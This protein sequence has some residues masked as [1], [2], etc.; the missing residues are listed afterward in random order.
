MISMNL[1]H[2][3][4]KDA[5]G[6][7]LYKTQDP[8]YYNEILKNKT[9]LLWG[10]SYFPKIDKGIRIT[11]DCAIEV[12]NPQT[13]EISHSAM[14]RVPMYNKDDL[15]INYENVYYPGNI[16]INQL[17]ST[18][19]VLNGLSQQIASALPNNQYYN[20]VRY[21][22]G[23]MQPNIITIDPVPMNHIDFTVDMQRCPRIYEIPVYYFEYF[24]NI[25][26]ADV[27][28]SLYVK[29]KPLIGSTSFQGVEINTDMIEV[30]SNGE[31]QRKEM[32]ELFE[33]NYWKDPSRY[34]S[35]LQFDAP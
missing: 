20:T 35:L 12:E 5:I 29:L 30:L 23:F 31:D 14:Y 9:L 19:Q 3:H 16:V 33:K 21:S 15:Y 6:E 17:G 1:L 13:G 4:I 8:S 10:G 25:F 28:S 22:F 26:I 27:K 11:R 32:I 18:N 7:V 34:G 24:K 2:W